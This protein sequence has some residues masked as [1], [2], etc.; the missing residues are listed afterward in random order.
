MGAKYSKNNSHC[1][2]LGMEE[3]APIVFSQKMKHHNL[4]T[5]HPGLLKKT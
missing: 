5:F 2:L 1:S 3:V 4:V